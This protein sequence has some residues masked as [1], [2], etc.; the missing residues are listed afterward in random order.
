MTDRPTNQPRLLD[1]G[2][3]NDQ[4]EQ[5]PLSQRNPQKQNS[6]ISH[7]SGLTSIVLSIVVCK[8]LKERERERVKGVYLIKKKERS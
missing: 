1:D 3:K 8:R 2:G 4:Q 5:Q 7:S 6:L